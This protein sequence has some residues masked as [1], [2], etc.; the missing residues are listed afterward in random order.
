MGKL[1][2]LINS[3]YSDKLSY[4]VPIVFEGRAMDTMVNTTVMGREYERIDWANS[5]TCTTYPL[6]THPTESNH[7]A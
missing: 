7:G 5:A 1:N 6:C 4:I 3:V 2:F